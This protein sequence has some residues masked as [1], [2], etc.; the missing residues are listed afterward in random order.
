[1]IGP[2]AE[3]WLKL[4]EQAASEQDPAKLRA[5]INEIDAL[6]GAKY[7]RLDAKV[8]PEAHKAETDKND[9]ANNPSNPNLKL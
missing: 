8:H 9:N 4:C 5:L 3:R 7:D 1:V 6:L 2:N